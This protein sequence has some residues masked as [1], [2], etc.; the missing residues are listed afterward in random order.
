MLGG[1][2]R[3]ALFFRDLSPRR[4]FPRAAAGICRARRLTPVIS[5]E[6]WEWSRHRQPGGLE[7]IAEGKHDAF[8][9]AWAQEAADY[10]DPVILRFGFE[11][12]G[13]WFA[14]GRQPELFKQVWRRVHAIF[15]RQNAVNVLWMFAPNVLSAGQ[16]LEVGL[17][18]YYPGDDVV[19]L[20][21]LDG[22]NFGDHHDQWH[23]WSSYEEVFERS[24][25]AARAW[26]KPL[27][28]S[29]VGCAA[30]PRKAAWLESF[31]QQVGA[32]PRV[33]GF[34]YFNYDKTREKEHNWRLDSDADSLRVFRAWAGDH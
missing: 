26:N 12:N 5:L 32:D 22:Y 3:S 21:G 1:H 7:E 18:P 30:D 20:V 14:W 10:G 29:E 27:I 9:T 15:E 28:I 2:P 19:D 8:F 13:D 23:A 33:E 11:M 16:K 6:L 17:V 25:V 34:I 24:I 31:L 4:G